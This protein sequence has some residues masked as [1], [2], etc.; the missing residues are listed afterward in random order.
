MKKEE[1]DR[2]NELYHKSK[3]AEGRT[4][5]E[6]IE[7]ANL[8]SAYIE[9][10]RSSMRASLD[11]VSVV[12]ADGSVVNLKDVRAKNITTGSFADEYTPVSDNDRE[13]KSGEDNNDG[14]DE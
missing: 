12:D 10:I 14:T 5:E 2:I 11:N 7:Q 6:K 8:R 1:I 13:D 4:P 9:S 3:T